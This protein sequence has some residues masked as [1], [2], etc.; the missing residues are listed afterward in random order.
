MNSSESKAS[1]HKRIG[2]IKNYQGMKK[3]VAKMIAREYQRES[4][5]RCNSHGSFVN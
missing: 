5:E 1:P 4:K 2:C 3:D